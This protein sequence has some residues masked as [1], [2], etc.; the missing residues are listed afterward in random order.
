MFLAVPILVLVA[1]IMARLMVHL[2]LNA[3]PV[4]A[5]VAAFFVVR[6]ADGTLLQSLLAAGGVA[7]AVTAFGHV[8]M[9]HLSNPVMRIL[10]LLG[11][12]GPAA[13]VAFN[14]VWTV[15]AP[16]GSVARCVLAVAAALYV[17]SVAW[18]KL[19]QRAGPELRE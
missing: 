9:R 19:L 3:L 17:G 18:Q 4:A 1:S 15:A 13:V 10:V 8:A 16:V 11:F 2:A 14:A 5:A 6:S 12:A 7:L